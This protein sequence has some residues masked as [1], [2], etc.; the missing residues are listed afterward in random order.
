MSPQPIL[1]PGF[2]LGSSDVPGLV[3]VAALYEE[4]RTVEDVAASYNIDP[5]ELRAH[6][7]TFAA[8]FLKR[9]EPVPS[10]EPGCKDVDAELDRSRRKLAAGDARLLRQLRRA[11]Q[12]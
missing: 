12:G 9:L 4:G 7:E 1:S 5:A 2:K 6:G 3:L 11:R 10:R 8:H